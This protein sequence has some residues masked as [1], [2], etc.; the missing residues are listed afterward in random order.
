V[1]TGDELR[2]TGGAAGSGIYKFIPDFPFAGGGPIA[3]AAT[4]ASQ[5]MWVPV[6]AATYA[7]VN[8]NVV[9]SAQT[10]L[11]GR[12]PIAAEAGD[13]TTGGCRTAAA[14]PSR[15]NRYTARSRQSAG[16]S[17]GPDRPPHIPADRLDRSDVQAVEQTAPGH[18]TDLP[19]NR[20]GAL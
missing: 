20:P 11:H 3:S 13:T 10:T 1:Y 17:G 16:D 19:S 18:I 4:T 8:S 6:N 2:P 12:D 15:P 5:G 7:D 14:A 9:R